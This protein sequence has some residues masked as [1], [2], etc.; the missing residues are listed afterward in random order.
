ML[1]ILMMVIQLSSYAQAVKTI[2]V[3]GLESRYKL[4]KDTVYI[5]N[6]WATWCKPCINELPYFEK[7]SATY[8]SRPVKVLLINVDSKSKWES[9]VVPFIKKNNLTNEVLFMNETGF[10]TKINKTWFGAL[11]ATQFVS[12]KT[13]KIKFN[14]GAL[15]YDELLKTYME[16]AN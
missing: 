10:S 2:T 13:G 3:K 16:F 4:G 15:T 11:P 9:S 14:A 7:L 8:K 5:V 6:F 1:L 12:A